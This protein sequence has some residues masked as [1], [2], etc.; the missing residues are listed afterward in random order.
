MFSTE[1]KFASDFITEWFQQKCKNRFFELDTFAR[2]I[3]L[4]G[5]KQNVSFAIAHYWLEWNTIQIPTK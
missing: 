5:K 2:K 3:Q 4:I 1:L